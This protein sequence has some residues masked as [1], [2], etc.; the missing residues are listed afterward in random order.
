M[1][2]EIHSGLE[3]N[4]KSGWQNL[5]RA[6]LNQRHF[7]NSLGSPAAPSHGQIPPRR[8]VGA[9]GPG[10][11]AGL[12]THPRK[13]HRRDRDSAAS[14]SK[15]GVKAARPGLLPNLANLPPENCYYYSSYSFTKGKHCE[16]PDADPDTRQKQEVEP[17]PLRPGRWPEQT[18]RRL[19]RGAECPSLPH[20]LRL[21]RNKGQGSPSPQLA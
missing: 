2:L 18:P 17:S 15:A 20:V 14:P 4:G 6:L 21:L 8:G 1:S 9:L 3:I 13:L 19:N 11:A 5:F 16:L 7:K 10:G 12:C